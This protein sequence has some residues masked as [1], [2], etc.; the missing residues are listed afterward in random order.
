MLMKTTFLFVFCFGI[1]SFS[2]IYERTGKNM[3]LYTSFSCHT[4]ETF[5]LPVSF[6]AGF[7]TMPTP[8]IFPK[9]GYKMDIIPSREGFSKIHGLEASV[10]L[11]KCLLKTSK[12]IRVMNACHYFSI[13]LI[14]A[15][16]YRCHIIPNAEQSVL[17]EFSGLAGLSFAHISKRRDKRSQRFTRQ[18]DVFYRQ[19]F[20]PSYQLLFSDGAPS[21]LRMEIGMNIRF[22]HHRVRN[23]LE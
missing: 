14:L 2:Q 1:Y 16:E 6:S 20:S 8:G 7:L 19:G 13:G 3:G 15:P 12:G 9:L 23:F 18:Y 5:R 21:R 10:Q 4:D 22:M 17:H 11:D